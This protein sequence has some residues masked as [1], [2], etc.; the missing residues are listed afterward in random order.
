MEN[1]DWRMQDAGRMMRLNDQPTGEQNRS[2]GARLEAAVSVAGERQR[3]RD[4][5]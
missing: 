1:G 2:T 5:E 4:G 3:E